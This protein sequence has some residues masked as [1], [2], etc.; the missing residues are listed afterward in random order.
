[1][2]EKKTRAAQAGTICVPSDVPR[3]VI[4]ETEPT[5][6]EIIVGCSPQY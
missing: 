6:V 2:P 4:I 3:V 1:M 5:P